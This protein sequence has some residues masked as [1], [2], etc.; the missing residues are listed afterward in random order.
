MAWKTIGYRIESAM[1]KQTEGASRE[2]WFLDAVQTDGQRTSTKNITSGTKQWC[3]DEKSRIESAPH[4]DP[5]PLSRDLRP[6]TKVE[7]ETIG[8]DKFVGML[9]AWDS[10][11]A[12]VEVGNEL[13]AVEC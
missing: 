4:L 8:G 5:V 7:W 13:K 6:P 9:A 3:D 2:I 10:N 12:L 1:I 11:V